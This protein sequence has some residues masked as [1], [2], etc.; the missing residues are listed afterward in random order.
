[1]RGPRRFSKRRLLLAFLIA[2]LSDIVG[3]TVTWIPPAVWALDLATAIALFLVLGWSWLL[4]PG[5][6]MEAIPG[7]EIL[8]FWVLVVGAIA[9]FGSPRPR[10]K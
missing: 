4:L 10:F 7:F 2:C 6:V 8:P 3:A 1:M 9:I 5:L